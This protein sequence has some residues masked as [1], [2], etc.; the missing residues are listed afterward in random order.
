MAL[1]QTRFRAAR[2]PTAVFGRSLSNVRPG[3]IVHWPT[4]HLA[5]RDDLARGQRLVRLDL[6]QHDHAG[7][8]GGDQFGRLPHAVGQPHEDRGGLVDEVERARNDVTARVDYPTGR[9]AGAEEHP[10]DRFQAA[11]GFDADH[12]RRDAGNGR[13]EGGLLLQVHVVGRMPQRG[14]TAAITSGS[15]TRTSHG[16][17]G[18]TSL[19]RRHRLAAGPQRKLQQ[20]ARAAEHRQRDFVLIVDELQLGDQGLAGGASSLSPGANLTRSSRIRSSGRTPAFSAGEPGNT[21]STKAG[22]RSS[23]SGTSMMPSAARVERPLGLS[24]GVALPAGRRSCPP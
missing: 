5:L 13:L 12:R 11:D 17:R 18:V 7:M 14:R 9:R 8:I 15:S 23:T 6:Q 20:L 1:P 19:R 22:V 3:A 10:F 16:N 2:I 4:A 21:R 24:R